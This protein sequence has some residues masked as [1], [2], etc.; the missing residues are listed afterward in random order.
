MT[1][2]VFV[3]TNVLVYARDASEP[4]KQPRAA[5]WLHELWTD[6]RGRT[7]IQVLSEY[8]T[9]VTRKLRP[10]LPADEAW[11]DV[12]ALLAWEPQEIDRTVIVRARDIERRHSLSWWD[13][14]IVAAAQL[15]N[16]EVLLSE[17]LQHGWT[18][19][20]VTVRNPFVEGT[21]DA[22]A[23]YAASPAPV[24]RHRPRGRPLSRSRSR[25]R[26]VRA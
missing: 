8:Y 6:Q 2:T 10:G 11:E 19:G 5:E 12:T 23:S 24:S 17:D 26:P 20:T 15:Q 16:C 9:T 25:P 13:A 22:R 14:M 3:D 21:E 4:L 7:S 18:C 1:A